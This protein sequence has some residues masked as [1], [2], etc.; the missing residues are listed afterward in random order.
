MVS[1]IYLMNPTDDSRISRLVATGSNYQIHRASDGRI[2]AL[3]DGLNC[4]VSSSCGSRVYFE[5][6]CASYSGG[7]ETLAELTN[8]DPYLNIVY[9]SLNS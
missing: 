9:K 4:T 6:G 1:Y 2:Y 8:V 3:D 7:C 5:D